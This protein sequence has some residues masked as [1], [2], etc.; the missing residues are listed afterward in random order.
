MP[1][2]IWKFGIL[3]CYGFFSFGFL[4]IRLILTPIL[5][6]GEEQRNNSGILLRLSISIP[7]ADL[8]EMPK[9]TT[10][11]PLLEFYR[12]SVNYNSSSISELLK[13]SYNSESMSRQHDLCPIFSPL[14]LCFHI[15]WQHIGKAAGNQ[16][17][18]ETNHKYVGQLMWFYLW[19][20]KNG[21]KVSP[22]I[23]ILSVSF[24]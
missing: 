6:E 2:P 1:K 15:V 24:D 18:I 9:D 3:M 14:S 20:T 5:I 21:I 10:S 4:K 23:G 13:I 22:K 17:F 19:T 16:Y 8:R 12:D 11:V 7:R